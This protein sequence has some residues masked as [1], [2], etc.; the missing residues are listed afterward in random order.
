MTVEE[1]ESR[2]SDADIMKEGKYV[3]LKTVGD[4]Q[5]LNKLQKT[6]VF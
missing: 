1:V 6:C 5:R 3:I 4:L 2:D